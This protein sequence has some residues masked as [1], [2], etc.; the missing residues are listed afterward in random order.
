MQICPVSSNTKKIIYSSVSQNLNKVWIQPNGTWI[1]F[2]DELVILNCCKLYMYSDYLNVLKCLPVARRKIPAKPILNGYCG[3][4]EWD[5]QWTWHLLAP[6]NGVK[7][8]ISTVAKDNNFTI[9]VVESTKKIKLLVSCIL[10]AKKWCVVNEHDVQ[11]WLRKPWH[12]EILLFVLL[13]NTV[14]KYMPGL[15]QFQWA[16]L[17]TGSPSNS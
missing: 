1:I 12:L 8:S 5:M 14:P 13:L 4:Y 7:L 10:N 16:D 6:A 11:K 17:A 15:N 3:D 9:H 2:W